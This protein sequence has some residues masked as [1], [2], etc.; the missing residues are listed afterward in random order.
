MGTFE[1]KLICKLLKL[2]SVV[3][4]RQKI[5]SLNLTTSKDFWSIPNYF[6]LFFGMSNIFRVDTPITSTLRRRRGGG[7]GEVQKWDVI[8]RR[9]WRIGEC[10]G[11]PIFFYQRKLD[12][13]HDQTSC[14]AK[15]W[16]ILTRNLPFDSDV[17]QW[18]HPLTI[19]LHFNYFND[20]SVNANPISVRL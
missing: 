9:G 4:I 18:S 5:N 13:R 1:I 3:I 2:V 14:S 10:S 20:I 12:L 8:G 19:P 15:H 11:R 6:R 16:Y 17:R 7:E